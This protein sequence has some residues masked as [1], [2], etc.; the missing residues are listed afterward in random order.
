MDNGPGASLKVA[1]KVRGREQV[2]LG[3][4]GG[5]RVGEGLGVLAQV[6]EAR[7]VQ[8]MDVAEAPEQVTLERGDEVELEQNRSV[9][10]LGNRSTRSLENWSVRSRSVTL[11]ENRSIRSLKNWT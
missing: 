3:D 8:F 9:R 6:V 5:G 4:G 10:S 2:V 11:R 1:V 7:D